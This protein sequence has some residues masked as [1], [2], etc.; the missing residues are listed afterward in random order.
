MKKIILSVILVAVIT[1]AGKSQ[2]VNELSIDS[3]GTKYVEIVGTSSG[4]STKVKILVDFGQ[5]VKSGNNFVVDDQGNKM[6]FTSM[7]DALN[8]FAKHGYVLT[9]AYA[10]TASNSN[11]YHYLLIKE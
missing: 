8:L 6:K 3:F 7:V 1:L 2:T 11:V 5:V 9:Q 10:V 4:F